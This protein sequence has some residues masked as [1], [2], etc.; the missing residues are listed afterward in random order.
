MAPVLSSYDVKVVKVSNGVYRFLK[1][2]HRP[3]IPFETNNYGN[4]H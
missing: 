1:L 4:D 2:E 3:V